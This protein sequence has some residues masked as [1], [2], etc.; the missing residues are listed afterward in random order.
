MIGPVQTTHPKAGS[1]RSISSPPPP[2]SLQ[3]VLKTLHA[4]PSLPSMQEGQRDEKQ[5]SRMRRIRAA[6]SREVPAQKDEQAELL[7]LRHLVKELRAITVTV[8]GSQLSAADLPL[9]LRVEELHARAE[10]ATITV[11]SISRELSGA[12]DESAAGGEDTQELIKQLQAAL[13][14]ER[15]QREQLAE[16][17]ARKEVELQQVRSISSK[18]QAAVRQ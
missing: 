18:S 8:D 6:Q 1:R 17:L 11:E 10:Q 3:A 16:A 9:L 14:E 7:R 13:G 2:K 5:E 15:R 12:Q 4:L